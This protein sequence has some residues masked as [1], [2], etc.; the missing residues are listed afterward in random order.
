MFVRIQSRKVESSLIAIMLIV[1]PK[2]SPNMIFSEDQT[3]SKKKSLV[4]I[5]W[6]L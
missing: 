1:D 3:L 6:T 2:N 4:I 5:S